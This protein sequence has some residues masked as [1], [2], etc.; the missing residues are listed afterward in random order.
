VKSGEDIDQIKEWLGKSYVITES[1]F[2]A[3]K[4]GFTASAFH[5]KCDNKGACITL[6]KG[7]NG[8]IFGGYTSVGWSSNGSYGAD[9]A[10]FLFH[11]TKKA[12][13]E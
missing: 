13:L 9:A 5:S 12:K 7:K 10:A 6:V 4:D 8:G 1:I 3:S 11:V 2:R